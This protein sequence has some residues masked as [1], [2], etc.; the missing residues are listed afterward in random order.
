MLAKIHRLQQQKDVLQVIRKGRK[1]YVDHFLVRSLPN[2]R[3]HNRFCFVVS[4]KVSKKAAHRNVLKRRMREAIRKNVPKIKGNFDIVI[5]VNPKT[6]PT[7]LD[8]AAV[9]AELTSAIK[10]LRLWQN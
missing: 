4:N 10:K 6:T 1:A 9:E 2:D 3:E 8:F 7:E 5:G